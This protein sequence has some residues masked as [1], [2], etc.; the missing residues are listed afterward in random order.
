LT[1]KCGEAAKLGHEFAIKSPKVISAP[2][3][4][5]F[6]PQLV[7]GLVARFRQGDREAADQLVEVLYPELRRIAASKMRAERGEHSWQPTVLVNELYLELLKVKALRDPEDRGEKAAF[8]SFAAFLMG[9]LLA[10]HARPAAK[11]RVK[12]ALDDQ[13]GPASLHQGSYS[14][15]HIDAVLDRLAAIDP[16][17]RTVVEMRVFEGCTG[18][19]IASRMGCARKTVDRYWTFAKRWLRQ[20]LAP[21]AAS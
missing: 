9:R 3:P 19:E 16:R 1:S 10:R 6:D 11:K 14:L 5:A 4:P 7:D 21:E 17:F 12:V 2:V 15:A 13:D 18:E 20:E 8:M